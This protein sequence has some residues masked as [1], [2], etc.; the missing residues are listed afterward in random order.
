M[1]QRVVC[2]AIRVGE[3]VICGPRHFDT[4]MRKT[5]DSNDKYSKMKWWVGAEEGFVD[6]YGAFL[7]REEAFIVATDANQIIRRVG[8]DDKKLFSE[9]LY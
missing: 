1:E 2:A 7:S 3:D 8:G 5:I 6:Q 9:N 4:V